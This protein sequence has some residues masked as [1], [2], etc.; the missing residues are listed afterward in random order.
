MTQW[1]PDTER[2][3]LA[4]RFVRFA[5][6]E[7]G[8]YA[9]FYDQLARGIAH[10]PDLLTIAAYSRS[11]QQAPNLFLAAVHYLLLRGSEHALTAFYP[12]VA[13]L[14]VVPPGDPVPAFHSFCQDH[15]AALI[16]LISTG[17]VQTNEPQRC[18]VLL[19]AFATVGRLTGG[20]PL[21]LI[22]VGAS[23]GLN[24]LFDRYG[25]DYGAGRSAGD[26]RS[27][28][29]F[30]CAPRGSRL[31]PIHADMLHV[32]T[33]LG[34]DLNPIYA[35][36]LQALLWLRALVWPEHPERA[37]RLQQVLTLAQRQPPRLIAGDA[38]TV[39]PQVVADATAGTA[40]CVFHTATLAH[41]P[42]EARERFR[43]LIPELARQRD[44]FWLASEGS[45]ELGRRGQYATILTA[46]QNGCRTEHQLAYSHPHGAW[47]EW[48][49]SGRNA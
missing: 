1:T 20:T 21:A 9:P 27:P 8:D 30:A 45:G 24:L 26:P 22:E 18:T 17:L 19:P 16:E 41:F 11:G 6:Q 34:I 15:R 40:L 12:S 36:D 48:L 33:R 31:P 25:Y 32:G 5:D 49:D 46:F 35:N 37:V 4:R 44:L 13:H 7:C 23:A 3:A 43:S 38:L 28:V 10:D 47:L 14:T 29:R 39:L 42:P 2:D